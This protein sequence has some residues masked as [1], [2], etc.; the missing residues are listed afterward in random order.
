MICEEIIPRIVGHL[1]ESQIAN[2]YESLEQKDADIEI[3]GFVKKSGRLFVAIKKDGVISSKKYEDFKKQHPMKLISYLERYLIQGKNSKKELK[4][5][6][7]K[8]EGILFRPR[9][10]VKELSPEQIRQL[11]QQT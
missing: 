11:Q 6:E 4:E 5:E 1:S 3:I 7:E 9:I 8:E 2:F 10:I